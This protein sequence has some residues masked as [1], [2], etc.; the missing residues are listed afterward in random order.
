MKPKLLVFDFDGTLADSR[1]LYIYAIH[2]AINSFGYGKSRQEVA[3]VL[4]PKLSENLVML[5]V[6][7]KDREAIRSEVNNFMLGNA[8]RVRPCPHLGVLEKLAEEYK[9]VLLTNSARAFVVAWL[10]KFRLLNYFDRLFCSRSFKTKVSALKRLA[11]L[12]RVKLGEVVY[13][14]DMKRG[15]RISKKAGCCYVIVLARAW[16]KEKFSGRESYVV[17]SLAGL[18]KKLE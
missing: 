12:Y 17:K 5:G 18:F 15:V 3:R 13:I 4:G 1:Q 16:D 2:K 9:L 6:A 8:S 14:G 7:G 11:R 10:G